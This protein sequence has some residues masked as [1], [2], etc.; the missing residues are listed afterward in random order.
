MNLQFGV[1]IVVS[2]LNRLP[3]QKR[4]TQHKFPKLLSLDTA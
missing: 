4:Q 3:I 1:H 2:Y